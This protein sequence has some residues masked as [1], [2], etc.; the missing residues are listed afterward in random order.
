MTALI[1]APGVYSTI[2]PSQY[3]AEICPAPAI[4]NSLIGSLVNQTARHAWARHPQLGQPVEQKKS[5]ATQYKGSLVHRLSLGKGSDFALSPYDEFR[6]NEAKAWR[7]GMLARDII[8]VKQKDYDEAASMAEIAEKAI[9]IAVDGEEY[10]TEVVFAW[11]EETPSG[12][13]WAR[14]MADIWVPSLKLIVDLKTCADAS[15]DK[16]DSSFT[17][18]GYGRQSTWYPRG[19]DKIHDAPGETRFMDLFIETEYPYCTRTADASEGMRTGCEQE[20]ERAVALWGEC[21]YSDN[22]PGYEHRRVS[23]KPW[24]IGSWLADGIEVDIEV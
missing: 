22:W 11:I 20:I 7:D 1:T 18:Y 16:V 2:T 15:D 5:T 23:P 24:Q 21:L 17:R 8:P 6:S 12:P 3:F 14:A 10:E 19:M 13:V 9:E 4:T